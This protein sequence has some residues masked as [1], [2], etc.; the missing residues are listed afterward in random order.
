MEW[1][2]RKECAI[3]IDDPVKTEAKEV[4]QNLRSLGLRVVMLTGDSSRVAKRGAETTWSRASEKNE[5]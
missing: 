3:M 2:I 1:H 4:I 5:G